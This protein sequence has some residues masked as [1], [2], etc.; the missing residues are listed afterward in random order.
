MQVEERDYK[1]KF[2]LVVR[3]DTSCILLS[4]AATRGWRICQFDIKT[5]FLNS[6]IDRKLYTAEPQGYKTSKGNTCFLNKT[7]YRLVQSAYLWFNKIKETLL[8]YD[9]IQLKHDDALFYNPQ[10]KMYVTVYVDNIKT[11][12]PADTT[13]DNLSTFISE[14][15]ELTD[16]GD[17]K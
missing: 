11:F 1:K 14:K 12:A 2:A 8:K 6:N 5:A 7:L 4:V 3:S 13:I 15:Y 9:L 17:L 16:L 10:T